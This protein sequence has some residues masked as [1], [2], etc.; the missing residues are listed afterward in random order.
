VLS[1]VLGNSHT[2][3]ADG[4]RHLSPRFGHPANR[5]ESTEIILPVIDGIG[6]EL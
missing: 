2:Q 4:D 3:V 1:D 6:A 5:S